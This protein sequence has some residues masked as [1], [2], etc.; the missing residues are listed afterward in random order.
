M[1][2]VKLEDVIQAVLK[3]G[4]SANHY[5]LLKEMINALPTKEDDWVSVETALPEPGVLVL[6]WYRGEYMIGFNDGGLTKFWYEKWQP[7][8][9]PPT[10]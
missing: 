3:S 5:S 6:C 8:P 4:I 9:S 2:Y 10:K 1:K 7:L